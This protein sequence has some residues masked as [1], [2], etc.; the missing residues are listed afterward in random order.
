M[1]YRNKQPFEERRYYELSPDSC[2][3]SVAH[4]VHPWQSK[5]YCQKL[6]ILI[7]LKFHIKIGDFWRFCFDCHGQ[8]KYATENPQQCRES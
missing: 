8:N 4:L 3:F 5:Q 7:F 6:P 1:S 2:R